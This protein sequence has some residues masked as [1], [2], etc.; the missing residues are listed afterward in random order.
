MKSAKQDKATGTFNKVKGAIKQNVGKAASDRS[1]ELEGA[2]DR[3]KGKAQ[4][5]VGKIKDAAN[6]F[7]KKTN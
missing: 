4:V 1:L 2:G 7:K 5:A 3:L 6:S